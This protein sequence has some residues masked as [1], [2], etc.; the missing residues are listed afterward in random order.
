MFAGSFQGQRF[1]VGMVRAVTQSRSNPEQPADKETESS[2]ATRQPRNHKSMDGQMWLEE[3][4]KKKKAITKVKASNKMDKKIFT[5]HMI[6]QGLM[7]AD[8]QSL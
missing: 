1:W 4:A 3:D 6:K 2:K 8:L 5:T 7:D